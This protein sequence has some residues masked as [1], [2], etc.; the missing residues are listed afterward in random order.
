MVI[1]GNQ[2]DLENQ[3]LNGI[4]G[5]IFFP[6]GRQG[7]FCITA[8]HPVVP[9]VIGMGGRCGLNNRYFVIKKVRPVAPNVDPEILNLVLS[10]Y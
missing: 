10:G 1:M 4:L 5:L 7:S 8:F 3:S 9:I 2:V 6:A